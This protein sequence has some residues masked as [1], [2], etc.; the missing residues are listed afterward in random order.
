MKKKYLEKKNASPNAKKIF[1]GL[2]TSEKKNM[3]RLKKR[4]RELAAALPVR[5]ERFV[6]ELEGQSSVDHVE[7]PVEPG[8]RPLI[9]ER[10]RNGRG[11]FISGNAN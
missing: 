4:A 2:L 1:P 10:P 8:E 11:Q 6:E 9:L 3:P 5:W 7:I